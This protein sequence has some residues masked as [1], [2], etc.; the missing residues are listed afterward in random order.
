[1][2]LSRSSTLMQVLL[3]ADHNNQQRAK[4]HSFQLQQY[5][6]IFQAFRRWHDIAAEASR[7]V[8]ITLTKLYQ[9]SVGEAQ[10]STC[11]F[12]RLFKAA[13]PS[14]LMPVA[15]FSD[16][17]RKLTRQVRAWICSSVSACTYD[18]SVRQ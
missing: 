8:D 7:S 5:Y 15:P 3:T 11:N 17:S 18:F 12:E 9:G 16:S 13:S 14:P 4:V 6:A 10:G 2:P 1:M